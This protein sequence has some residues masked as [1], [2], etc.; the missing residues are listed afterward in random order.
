[1]LKNK[2]LLYKDRIYRV[3]ADDTEHVS[4][5]EVDG[6]KEFTISRLEAYKLLYYTEIE[7]KKV[8]TDLVTKNYIE[9]SKETLAWREKFKEIKTG[10]AELYGAV[11]SEDTCESFAFCDA[12]EKVEELIEKVECKEYDV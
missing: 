12:L 11:T 3:I 2:T 10:V 6:A 8:M 7:N 5:K 1:M 9:S 4:I